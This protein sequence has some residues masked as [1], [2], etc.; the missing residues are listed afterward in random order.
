METNWIFQPT[1]P[2][3]NLPTLQL[4]SPNRSQPNFEILCAPSWIIQK[5]SPANSPMDTPQTSIS[6]RLLTAG[7]QQL[8]SESLQFPR[9][10]PRRRRQ[11]P[12]TVAF[13]GTTLEPTE[14]PGTSQRRGKNRGS[15]L[16]SQS[17]DEI[18]KLFTNSV[19][20]QSAVFT[21]RVKKVREAM[22]ANVDETFTCSL[23]SG[24]IGN[25]RT[26]LLRHVI[27]V[28][29]MSPPFKCCNCRQEFSRGDSLQRHFY[30]C[31]CIKAR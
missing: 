4:P 19:R 13:K 31:P 14:K 9:R 11:P 3:D 17:Y 25:G 27:R 24:I 29:L 21:E 12:G 20:K 18:Q 1:S 28:H 23:C 5:F 15:S 2:V 8:G 26:A 6:P 22:H 10:K 16:T 30:R 7:N